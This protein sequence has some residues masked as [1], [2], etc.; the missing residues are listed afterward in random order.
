MKTLGKLILVTLLILAVGVFSLFVGSHGVRMSAVAILRNESSFVLRN[1]LD[2]RGNDKWYCTKGGVGSYPFHEDTF[3]SS[4]GFTE[5][6]V[7]GTSNTSSGESIF[8]I[9]TENEMNAIEYDDAC[10]W[11]ESLI[12]KVSKKPHELT[13]SPPELLDHLDP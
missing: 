7:Y 5:N 2:L 3:I 13:L 4:I 11:H 8:F 1:G 9:W 6:A 12:L 10:L